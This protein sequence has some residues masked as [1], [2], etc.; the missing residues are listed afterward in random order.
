MKCE[1]CFDNLVCGSI[2]ET[3]Y[4][5]FCSVECIEK[6]N[7]ENEEINSPRETLLK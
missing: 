4:G 7:I 6:Y 5:N 2:I 3:V 1:Y